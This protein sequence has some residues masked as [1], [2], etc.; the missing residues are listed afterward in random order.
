MFAESQP[1]GFGLSG[2]GGA[3]VQTLRALPGL[4]GSKE[5]VTIQTPNWD[6]SRKGWNRALEP[7]W[8]AFIIPS[9]VLKTVA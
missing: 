8:G 4:L 1:C 2:L 3:Q 5:Q 7:T 6:I 9:L